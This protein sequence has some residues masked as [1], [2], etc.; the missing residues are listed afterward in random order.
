VSGT[1]SK[2]AIKK[3][4]A[5]LLSYYKETYMT[6]SAHF[7]NECLLVMLR[8]FEICPFIIPL[9]DSYVIYC[10]I[11]APANFKDTTILSSTA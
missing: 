3:L 7:F 10:L 8:D 5:D 2:P 4:L 1:F 11:S 9:K 6:K